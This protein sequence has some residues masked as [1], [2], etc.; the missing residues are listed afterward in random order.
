MRCP[1]WGA[2]GQGGGDWCLSH[3]PGLQRRGNQRA[4]TRPPCQWPRAMI[5]ASE[6][7]VQRQGVEV[8]GSSLRVG[9]GGPLTCGGEGGILLFGEGVH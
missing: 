8:D 3:W 2:E 9:V 4:S 1:E 6:W 5:L 7:G